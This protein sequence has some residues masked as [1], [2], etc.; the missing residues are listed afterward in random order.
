MRLSP[1]LAVVTLVVASGACG[2]ATRAP[3]AAPVEAAPQRGPTREAKAPPPPAADTC[4]ELRQSAVAPF[5][6]DT[7]T[8]AFPVPDIVDP[9]GA[10]RPFYD[11]LAALARGLSSDHVRIGVWGDSNMTADMITG[12]LRR[13]LQG[14]LGDG[15][16]GYVALA[17]PWRWYDHQDVHHDGTWWYFKQIATSTD[18][19]KDRHYGFANIAAE[20]REFRA[21]AWVET[22]P[23]TSPVGRSV[24]SFDLFYLKRP[25]GGQI[26]VLLDGEQSKRIQTRARQI[27]AGFERF[28]T[29]EGPHRLEVHVR[30]NGMVR[31]FGVAL[32]RSAPGVVVDSLGTGALNFQQMALVKSD[33]RRPMLERRKYDLAVFLLG[34]TMFALKQHKRWAAEVLQDLRAALPGVAILLMSPPDVMKAYRDAHSDPRI[35]EVR[36]Q[37]K[38]IAEEN[39]AAFWDFREAMGGDA[40]IKAFIQRGLAM[41][42]RVHLKKPG[43][44]LMADRFL[45]AVSRDWT[46]YLAQAPRAGCPAA[47]PPAPDATASITR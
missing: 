7:T 21:K 34:T 15:G 10:L 22:A 37:V 25:D 14:R 44:E 35:V 43:S 16:H 40:A 42:D 33:T 9:R 46:G 8:L 38:E 13:Q 30:G 12:R 18:P 39:G 19:V 20:T 32:E 23:V 17:K 47:G 5:E 29:F 1:R 45:C 6:C 3:T 4:P 24:S 28:E 27:E 26:D 2:G 41:V 11:R 36:D 31:L